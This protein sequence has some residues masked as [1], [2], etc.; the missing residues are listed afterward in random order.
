M[1]KDFEKLEIA[2]KLYGGIPQLAMALGKSKET[3]YAYKQEKNRIGRKLL[4][5]L[6]K[7]GLSREFFIGE[8]QNLFAD[9]E[10]GKALA[11]KH[12]SVAPISPTWVK[13]LSTPSQRIGKIVEILGGFEQA[14]KILLIPR[15]DLQEAFSVLDLSLSIVQPCSDVGF[16]LDWIILG[17]QPYYNS[18][19]KGAALRQAVETGTTAAWAMKLFKDAVT[20]SDGVFTPRTV[21]E[22]MGL[23]RI[24]LCEFHGIKD[25]PSLFAAFL[26]ER[27]EGERTFTAKEV[28][29]WE[30]NAIVANDALPIVV[31]EGINR[32]WLMTG[33]ET[34][35]IFAPGEAGK[36]LSK[37]YAAR[38]EKRTV[39]ETA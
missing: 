24:L 8:S 15:R 12:S 21:G 28:E 13:E 26:N 20:K 37:W 25:S 3:L 38:E 36:K 18:S 32:L 6:Y 29:D 9:N 2:A 33:Q 30:A 11:E 17:M 4:D 19:D 34:Q 14:E 39:L 23:V 5:E 22:R 16:S 1:Q 31:K 27:S 35:G 7:I 10:A